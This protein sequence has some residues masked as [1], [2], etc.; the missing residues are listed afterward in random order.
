MIGM[1]GH[2]DAFAVRDPAGIRPAYYY[3]DEE[4]AVVAS[5]RPAIQTACNVLY[6]DVHELPPGHAFII[7]KNGKISVEQV[8][9]KVTP[10]PCSFDDFDNTVFSFVPNTA[11]TAFYGMMKGIEDRLNKHKKDQILGLGSKIKPSKLEKRRDSQ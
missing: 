4:I 5:E 1:I 8:A 7:K 3:H 6:K 2:G 11:E 9:V 10:K